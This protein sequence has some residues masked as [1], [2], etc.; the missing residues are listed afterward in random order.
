[1]EEE[2]II[3]SNEDREEK[4]DDET[5][6]TTEGF[7]YP[8]PTLK[9]SIIR[10]FRDILGL[11]DDTKVSNLSTTDLHNVRLW[12]NTACYLEEEGCEEIADYFNAMAE[13]I[14]STAMSKDGFFLNTA[15]TQV[16]K[17]E[18]SAKAK[19]FV[20]KRGFLGFGGKEEEVEQNEAS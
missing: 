5:Y 10:F 20:K 1:M 19:R 11:K 18:R 15:V 4:F 3:G 16:R 12:K 8:T 9:D 13:N 17:V 2:P 7:Q 14:L 6:D